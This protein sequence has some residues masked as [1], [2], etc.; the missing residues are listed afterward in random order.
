MK[1]K[2]GGAFLQ[3]HGKG[4]HASM[5]DAA[6]LGVTE[7]DVHV[8]ANPTPTA[9]RRVA[10][11]P[12]LRPHHPGMRTRNATRRVR[13]TA[14]SWGSMKVCRQGGRRCRTMT[15][16]CA[17]R[18][19][20]WVEQARCLL[21]VLFGSRARGGSIVKGDVDLALHFAKLPDPARRLQIIGELQDTCGSD[22]VDVAFLHLRTDPVLRFEVFRTGRPLARLARVC[23]STRR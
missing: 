14:Y 4:N 23:S 7:V 10:E 3:W 6:I 20:A 19:A 17:S 12:L 22:D 13:R 18:I 1:Q 5:V 2:S 21:C 8:N 15:S 11:L 16:A 9:C